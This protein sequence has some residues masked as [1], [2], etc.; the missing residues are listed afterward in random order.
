[1]RSNRR[2]VEHRGQADCSPKAKY[3]NY[4]LCTAGSEKKLL[5]FNQINIYGVETTKAEVLG[6]AQEMMR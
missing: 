6:W 4:I 1:M 5:K 3:I 2:P